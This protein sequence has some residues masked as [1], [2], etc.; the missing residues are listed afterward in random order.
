MGSPG[1]WVTRLIYRVCTVNREDPKDRTR[2]RSAF[3]VYAGFLIQRAL[4]G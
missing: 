3:P 1:L 2:E 4:R